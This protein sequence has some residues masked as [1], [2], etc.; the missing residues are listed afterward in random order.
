VSLHEPPSAPEAALTAAAVD[1]EGALEVT[2]AAAGVAIVA[3]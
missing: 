3:E 2:A 1:G